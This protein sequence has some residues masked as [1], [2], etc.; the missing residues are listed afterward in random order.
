MTHP[1]VSEDFIN[2]RTFCWI[3]IQNFSDQ[4]FG[5]IRDC[6]ILREVVGV[7]TDSLVS[8]FNI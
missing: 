4:I 1:L 6:N 2:I 8:S 3:I 5:I 7:H